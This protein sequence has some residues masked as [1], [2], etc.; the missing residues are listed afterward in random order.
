VVHGVEGLVAACSGAQSDA[1]SAADLPMIEL[2]AA[3]GMG[4]ADRV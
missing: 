2:A 3:V 1:Q 4:D